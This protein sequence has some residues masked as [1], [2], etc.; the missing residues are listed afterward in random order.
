[1]S[2]ITEFLFDVSWVLKDCIKR[3]VCFPT[4]RSG[5]RISGA[6]PHTNKVTSIRLVIAASLTLS[7]VTIKEEIISWKICFIICD[8][9]WI[10]QLKL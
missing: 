10:L 2:V 4:H 9:C 3:E 5:E 7:K 8:V 6:L 1:M